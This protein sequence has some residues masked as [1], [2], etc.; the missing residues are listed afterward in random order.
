MMGDYDIGLLTGGAAV[1]SAVV[2]YWLAKK[3]LA[4]FK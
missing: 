1:A 3:L 2:F 4:L